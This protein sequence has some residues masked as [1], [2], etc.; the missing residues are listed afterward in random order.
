[1]SSL[2]VRTNCLFLH[3]PLPQ[4]PPLT[5]PTDA[6]W[7]FPV[8]CGIICSQKNSKTKQRKKTELLLCIFFNYFFGCPGLG[9]RVGGRPFSAVGRVLNSS[10]GVVGWS[11]RG[12]PQLRLEVKVDNSEEELS[13]L[14][15]PWRYGG[16]LSKHYLEGWGAGMKGEVEAAMAM[17]AAGR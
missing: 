13:I 14:I 6:L 2:S 5:S 8:T 16:S 7:L 4:P 12:P 10:T 11:G 9:R 3:L 17:A 1:M 15:R